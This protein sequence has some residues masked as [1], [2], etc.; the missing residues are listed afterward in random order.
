MLNFRGVHRVLRSSIKK[1]NGTESQRTPRCK[2]VELLDTR[3]FSGSVQERSCWR[4]L[5]EVQFSQRI[6]DF[7]L[8]SCFLMLCPIKKLD[9]CCVKLT[10]PP[11]NSFLTTK[12]FSQRS[13]DC[14]VMW[15]SEGFWGSVGHP[16][17]KPAFFA[18]PKGPNVFLWHDYISDLFKQ[19]LEKWVLWLMVQK[20]G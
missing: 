1:L 14:Y 20:S 16:K 18:K 15:G 13:N 5:G 6:S 19:L 8:I 11:K 3:V 17:K 10:H 12:L 9:R 7:F 4:F 2:L